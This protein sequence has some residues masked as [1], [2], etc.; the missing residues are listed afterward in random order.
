MQDTCKTWMWIFMHIYVKINQ[1]L[2]YIISLLKWEQQC[3]QNQSCGTENIFKLVSKFKSCIRTWNILY[4]QSKNVKRGLCSIEINLKS[5]M[6]STK[7]STQALISFALRHSLE[8]SSSSSACRLQF[9]SFVVGHLP[10]LNEVAWETL[11]SVALRRHREPYYL[12]SSI[13]HKQH[14]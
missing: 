11:Q 3:R 6:T 4:S 10:L 12:L 2:T 9:T 7:T 14:A 5:K 8:L 1:N 13:I